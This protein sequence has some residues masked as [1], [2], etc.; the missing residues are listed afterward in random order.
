[1]KRNVYAMEM[2]RQSKNASKPRS[3]IT[4]FIKKLANQKGTAKE[5][6][7]H[8]IDILHNEN[9]HP[10]ESTENLSITFETEKGAKKSLAFSTFQ[11]T[12]SKFKKKLP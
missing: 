5:K 7:S 9:M 11:K 6:W 1:M 3:T 2:G 12:L 10:V 4:P 8:L